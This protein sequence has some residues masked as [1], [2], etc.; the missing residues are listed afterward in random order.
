MNELTLE[1]LAKRVEALE[2]ALAAKKTATRPKDW[3]RVIGMFR[4]SDFMRQ[5]DEECLRAREA[6]REAAR[7]EES[8]E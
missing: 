4:D 7:H 6:E 2:I 8:T 1:S 5:V 3:R